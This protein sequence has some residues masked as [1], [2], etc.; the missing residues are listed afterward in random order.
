MLRMF[1][2]E[3]YYDYNHNHKE[4]LPDLH[5]L[6]V[7]LQAMDESDVLMNFM[8]AL[9]K[10]SLAPGAVPG[11]QPTMGKKPRGAAAVNGKPGKLR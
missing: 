7:Q 5:L 11:P 10:A 4:D 3:L 8:L 6:G 9:K 1:I 2:V